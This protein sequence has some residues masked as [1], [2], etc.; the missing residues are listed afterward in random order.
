M[1]HLRIAGTGSYLPGPPIDQAQLRAFLARHPDGLT[2]AEREHILRESGIA[3]RHLAVDVTDPTHRETNAT[4][5]AEAGGRALTAAGWKPEDVELLVVTTVVPD[6]LMPPTSTLVQEVLGIPRCVEYEISANC[7]APTKGLRIAAHELQLGRVERAL[8]C[9]VQCASFL[10]LPPW[11]KPEQ[12]GRTQAHVRWLLSDGA[13]AVALEHGW[14]DIE[15]RTWIRSEGVGKPSGMSLALGAAF[16]DLAACATGAHHVVQDT[17]YVLKEGIRH[18]V[19][20]LGRM[21]EDLA[22][23]PATIT[24]FIPSVASQKLVR[25]L[26]PLFAERLGIRPETWRLNFTRVGYAGSVAVP[27]M[28]DEL[29]QS[30]ALRPGDLV[31]TMAEESSKWMFAGS[32]FRWNP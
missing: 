31:C 21:F 25:I 10:G 9:M 22:I 24:H 19:A 32:A 18:C 4:M 17:R 8:V 14:P 6:Q 20:S 15:L 30:G 26:E 7:T 1:I 23:D 29:A 12:M 11:A 16:P 2:P 27:I 3:T 13:A 5:A 28:V